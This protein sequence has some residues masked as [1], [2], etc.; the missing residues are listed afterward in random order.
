MIKRCAWATEEK[1]HL[2]RYHDEEWG[3]PVHDDLM[4]FELVCL[5]GQQAGLSW[6]IILKKREAYR[7]LFH[8]FDPK[9]VALMTDKELSCITQNPAI[10][11]NTLKVFSIRT[12]ARA[13]LK[14]Q[15]AHGTFDAYIWSFVNG[16]PL[17]YQGFRCLSPE[18]L[19]ISK[20]LKI[21]GF[22]FVG[23]K[24]IYSYMQAAGLIFDHTPGCFLFRQP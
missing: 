8:G 20:E 5:E 4:H 16:I 15:A 22:T 19:L 7:T 3:V 18:S 14:I 1:P 10:I 17:T 9:K 12:N 23:P 6:E 2:A 11:R 13:F 21:Q 24:I